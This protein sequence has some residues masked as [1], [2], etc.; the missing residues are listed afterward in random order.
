MAAS[1]STGL[2]GVHHAEAAEDGGGRKSPASDASG[3]QVTLNDSHSPCRR[4]LRIRTAFPDLRREPTFVSFQVTSALGEERTPS[5][6]RGYDAPPQQQ[7][8]DLEVA[9]RVGGGA[10]EVES[11]SSLVWQSWGG[12]DEG[13]GKN[14]EHEEEEEDYPSEE[15]TGKVKFSRAK[16]QANHIKNHHPNVLLALVAGRDGSG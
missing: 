11:L 1:T 5:G 2:G 9:G 13:A 4:R 7:W 8:E 6:G 16:W 10:E 12:W 15:A 3:W 14:L